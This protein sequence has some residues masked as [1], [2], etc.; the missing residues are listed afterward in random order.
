MLKIKSILK[1]NLNKD[2]KN[3]IDKVEC[4]CEN[5]ILMVEDIDNLLMD[6][7]KVIY[8]LGKEHGYYEGYEECEFDI[9]DY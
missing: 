1:D 8:E 2:L 9:G 7:Y 3:K 5:G 4:D 6:L